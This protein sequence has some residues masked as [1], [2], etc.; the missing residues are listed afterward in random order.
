M[1][2]T[3]IL[4]LSDGRPGHFNLSEGIAAAIERLGPATTTRH[5]VRRGKWSGAVLAAMTRSRLP[6]AHML[7]AVHGIDAAALPGCDVIVSAGAETLAANIWLSRLR[8]VPNIFYGSLRMFAPTDFQLVLTSYSRNAAKPRHVLSLK[9][10]R[11]D[12][13]TLG[14]PMVGAPRTMGLLIGGDAGPIR[15]T[16]KDW[17]A[18]LVF[19]RAMAAQRGVRWQV[20]YSRRTPDSVSDALGTEAAQ[21]GTA[22]TRFLDVRSAGPGTLSELLATCDAVACTADSS[23]MISECVWARRPALSLAPAACSFTPDEQAY[24]NWLDASG[25]CRQLDISS[26]TA[27]V[28]QATLATLT[29]IQHNPQASLADLIAERL[30]AICRHGNRAR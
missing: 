17:A 23:S 29:P 24:R 25:W 28:A 8:G 22:I 7:A 19:M 5:E 2:P 18:L 16:V 3:R 27:D 20:A 30:P 6:P 26:A 11:L 14:A 10:S 12:P 13:D 15:Y 9:P 4:I 21:P 1:P